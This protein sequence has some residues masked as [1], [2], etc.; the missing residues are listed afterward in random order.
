[1]ST[2]EDDL[3]AAQHILGLLGP[4]DEERAAARVAAEPD[5][6]A[7]TTVWAGRLDALDAPVE[8]VASETLWEKI[9]RAVDDTGSAPGTRTLRSDDGI[10][11][12]LGPGI[13]RRLLYVDR[14]AGTQS[15]YIRMKEGAVMPLHSHD[16]TEECVIL[17]GRL[18]IG[19]S[20][21]AEGDF[22]LGFAGEDH[23]PI[24]AVTESLFFIHGAL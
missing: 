3:L 5:F 15:Y 23:Q 17:K 19:D 1:M 12:T 20:E 6:A 8:E 11:E 14:T 10:W 18:R 24:T 21:F 13:Q 4:E 22:H 7:R 9:E 16:R 2:E